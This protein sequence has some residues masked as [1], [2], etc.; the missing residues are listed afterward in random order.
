MLSEECCFIQSALKYAMI[1]PFLKFTLPEVQ[2]DP[3]QDTIRR[4]IFFDL[5]LSSFM[6]EEMKSIFKLYIL[7]QLEVI[8]FL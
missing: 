5:L 7:L 3:K 1:V 2:T 6:K 4:Y 8:A